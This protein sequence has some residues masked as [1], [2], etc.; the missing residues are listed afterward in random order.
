MFMGVCHPTNREAETTAVVAL[1]IHARRKK[2]HA[3]GESHITRAEGTRPVEAV[4][5]TTET[6]IATVTS[7]WKKYP[8]GLIVLVDELTSFNAINLNPLVKCILN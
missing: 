8:F 4:A 1:T 3:V 2:E 7:N 5:T 6:T